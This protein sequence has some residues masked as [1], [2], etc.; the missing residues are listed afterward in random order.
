MQNRLTYPFILVCFFL[1]SFFLAPVYSPAHKYCNEGI[2]YS[3]RYFKIKVPIDG[4]YR[5]DSA[6]LAQAGIPVGKGGTN[7]KFF[8]LF[9]KGFQQYIFIQGESDGVFNS[10]DYIEF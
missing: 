7:P 3:Q 5:V 2:N 4:I 9:N 6:A 1:A 8:Q 10:G